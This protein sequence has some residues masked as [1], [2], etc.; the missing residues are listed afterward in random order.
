MA[1]YYAH[2]ATRTDGTPDPNPERWQLLSTH[3]R[4]VADVAEKFAAPFNLAKEAKL[5]GLLHDL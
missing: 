2:T 4:N 1:T 3:L 5:A